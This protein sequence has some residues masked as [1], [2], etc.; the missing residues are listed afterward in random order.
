MKLECHIFDFDFSS[1]DDS[2]GV[3]TIPLPVCTDMDS[4]S[5]YPVEK[6]KG[7]YYCEDASGELK[8]NVQVKHPPNL[9]N[10]SEKL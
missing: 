3:V 7:V 10:A 1:D 6:G 5:W 4:T 8:V 9:Y 2:M